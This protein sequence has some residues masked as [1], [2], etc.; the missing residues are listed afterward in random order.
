VAA[1]KEA[2]VKGAHTAKMVE[3][4]RKEKHVLVN[5]RL[6]NGRVVRCGATPEF[7][8]L[9]KVMRASSGNRC[10]RC[11]TLIIGRRRDSH[12]NNSIVG[13]GRSRVA[14]VVRVKLEANV[15]RVG[16]EGGGNKVLWF[17]GDRITGGD[18][19]GKATE[20]AADCS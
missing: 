7:V 6:N 13:R 3:G 12:I 14:V 11:I 2:V 17:I 16:V 10:R 8:P 15:G 5:K 18:E 4:G 19:T 9:G 20:L 1:I